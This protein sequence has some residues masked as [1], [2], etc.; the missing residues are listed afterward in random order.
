MRLAAVLA[1]S[2]NTIC[3]PSTLIRRV[4]S[5]ADRIAKARWTTTSA[6]F[7]A[8]RTLPWSCTSPCRYSVFFQPTSEESKGRRAMPMMRFTRRERSSAETSAMPRS[9]VGPVTATV[10]PSV[11]IRGRGPEVG[12]RR[13]V[14]RFAWQ[15]DR[16]GVLLHQDARHHRSHVAAEGGL[17]RLLD[18]VV[19]R[20]LLE[21]LDR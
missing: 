19:L 10:R 9:P 14:P 1:A 20:E 18:G 5:L 12:G 8:S 17:E 11:G 3:E 6:P 13:F 21:V 16:G 2:S 15:D 7:T 4:A